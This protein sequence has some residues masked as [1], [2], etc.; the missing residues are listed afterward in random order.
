MVL[1]PPKELGIRTR[2]NRDGRGSDWTPHAKLVSTADRRQDP[3]HLS[4]ERTPLLPL[5]HHLPLKPLAPL[6]GRPQLLGAGPGV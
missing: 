6:L 3:V 4:L 5:R 2:C 1:V